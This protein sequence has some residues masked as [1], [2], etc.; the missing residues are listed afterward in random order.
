MYTCMYMSLRLVHLVAPE[1][2]H[3][4]II[5]MFT[6]LYIYIYT[7]KSLSLYIYIYIYIYE[8]SSCAPCRPRGRR[9]RT[10]PARGSPARSSGAP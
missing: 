7:H 6:M 4:Y 9:C 8:P 2:E 5:I 10:P 3:D 1:G